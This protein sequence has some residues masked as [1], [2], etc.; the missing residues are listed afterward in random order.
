[1]DHGTGR[2]TEELGASDLRAAIGRTREQ[3]GAHLAELKESFTPSARAERPGETRSTATKK[4]TSPKS[5]KAKSPD[6]KSA[7]ATNTGDGKSAKAASKRTSPRK[8][9]GTMEKVGEV[10]DTMV[11][12]A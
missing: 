10:L 6:G 12:G 3:L 7:K 5:A 1:M 11:A 2:D 8:N 4:T 9:G